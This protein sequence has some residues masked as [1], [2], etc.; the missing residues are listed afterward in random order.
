[1][2]E[3]K[4]LEEQKWRKQFAQLVQFKKEH[5][6]LPQRRHDPTLN[7]WL[8]MQRKKAK[9]GELSEEQLRLYHEVGINVLG[10]SQ[11]ADLN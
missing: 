2:N 6:M 4:A 8:T 9:S 3:F 7:Y 5:G 10:R 1:M 11:K